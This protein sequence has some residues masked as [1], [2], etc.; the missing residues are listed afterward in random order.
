MKTYDDDRFPVRC[1]IAASAMW[2]CAFLL[3]RLLYEGTQTSSLAPWRWVL[4]GLLAAAVLFTVWQAFRQHRISEASVK[5]QIAFHAEL[6][7]LTND[8][9]KGAP[10]AEITEQAITSLMNRVRAPL[11]I[12]ATYGPAGMRV[13]AVR[14][15]LGHPDMLCCELVSKDVVAFLVSQPGGRCI[16]ANPANE[17]RFDLPPFL[18]Q[19][20][21]ALALEIVR[22]MDDVYGL[23]VMALPREP[24][25]R[26]SRAR[27]LTNVA[28]LLDQANR[29]SKIRNSKA[30]ADT[31]FKQIAENLNDVFYIISFDAQQ[32]HYINP[33]YEKVWGR[34]CASLYEKPLSFIDAIH[35]DDQAG[36]ADSILGNGHPRVS[37]RTYRIID[38]SG[39][40]RWIR[41]RCFPILDEDGK[42]SRIGGL[43]VDVTESRK[44]AE[45]R[46]QLAIALGDKALREAEDSLRARDEILAMVSHDLRGPLT[47]ISLV[48]ERM[49]RAADVDPKMARGVRRAQASAEHMARLLS[50]LMDATRL[51]SG[52]LTLDMTGIS[53]PALIDAVRDTFS[54]LCSQKHITLLTSVVDPNL[55][56]LTLDHTRIL[57]AFG[58]IVGN[59]IKFTPEYGTI[60]ISIT[61]AD[62]GIAFDIEDSG[63]GIAPE[64]IGKIFEPFW[65]QTR[66]AHRGLGL[67]LHIAR[68]V[69]EAHSGKISVRSCLGVGT[70][71]TLTLPS[72]YPVELP[73]I[74]WVGETLRAT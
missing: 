28:E 11:F 57:Q 23:L 24:E 65:Q 43:A 5:K 17:Q 74:A 66:D 31:W 47:T 33:A 15:K 49:L 9:L 59:A 52:K 12:F 4:D 62:D 18:A 8:A 42:P 35:P 19:Q 34:S 10:V 69:I 37:D 53:A 16:V 30:M 3:E 26:A 73:P 54:D 36:I 64:S 46:E 44:S 32:V 27:M 25:R 72:T 70:C 38:A 60:T 63:P 56:T 71:F 50:D 20:Q 55:P 29:A 48:I 39:G 21:Y 2:A 13:D 7:T 41:D 68:S 51:N 67:G 1:L 58:N 22:S 40:I 45:Q 6:C 61:E 14:G